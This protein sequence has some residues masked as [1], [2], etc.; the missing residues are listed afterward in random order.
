MA[1]LIS[2]LW[3]VRCGWGDPAD[4]AGWGEGESKWRG[5]EG[6]LGRQ[7]EGAHGAVLIIWWHAASSAGRQEGQWQN[8]GQARQRRKAVGIPVAR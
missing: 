5:D 2:L 4:G 1:W 8:G 3:L 6:G 7:G